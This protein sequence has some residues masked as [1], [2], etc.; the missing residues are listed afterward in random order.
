[1]ADIESITLSLI[2][3]NEVL[4]RV[5]ISQ[6]TLYRRMSRGEFPRQLKL[7]SRSFWV[8][9]EIHLF[10]E[11][12]LA[13]RKLGDRSRACNCGSSTPRSDIYPHWATGG[14][15]PLI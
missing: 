4:H 5:K 6:S 9:T 1:M 3:L 14:S 12:M 7:G 13:E 15:E 2:D 11:Q 8:E 10:I